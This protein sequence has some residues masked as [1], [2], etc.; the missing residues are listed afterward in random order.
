MTTVNHH[1]NQNSDPIK[2]RT[3]SFVPPAHRYYMRNLERIGFMALEEMPFEDV[4][5]RRRRTDGQRMPAYTI[6]LPMSLGL[7]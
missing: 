6:G 5:G 1:S 3:P 4:D 7:R 2:I